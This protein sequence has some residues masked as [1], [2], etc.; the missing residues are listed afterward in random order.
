MFG[1]QYKHDNYYEQHSGIQ[2]NSNAICNSGLQTLFTNVQHNVQH[3]V[4]NH[5]NNFMDEVCNL[6]K[7]HDDILSITKTRKFMI[8]LSH[9]YTQQAGGQ[10]TCTC[11]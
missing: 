4:R 1:K 2:Q 10:Y 8:T 3:T 5:C 9:S 6:Q 11:S 7:I